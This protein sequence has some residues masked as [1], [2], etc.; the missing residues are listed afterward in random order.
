MGEI[1]Q[2][3]EKAH[4]SGEAVTPL[5]LPVVYGEL[6]RM[7]AKQLAREK[8]GQTIS[9]TALVHEAFIRMVQPAD[10]DQWKNR[11]HFFGAAA[12]AMRRI[13]VEQARRKGRL[14]HGGDF[15]RIDVDLTQ[16]YREN[17]LGK[18]SKVDIIAVD[19]ALSVFEQTFPQEAELVKLRYFGG[20]TMQEA[21]NCLEISRRTAQRYYAFAKA[22]LYQI[23]KD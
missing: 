19:E 22:K 12:E 5:L 23:I 3:I 8:P 11:A 15:S 16:L 6:K 20:L 17:E 13:L 10:R 7:A 14:R 21:S 4:K 18:S 9:A 2:I 1:T